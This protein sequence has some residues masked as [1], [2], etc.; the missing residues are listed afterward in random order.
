M[1]IPSPPPSVLVD[2]PEEDLSRLGDALLARVEDVLDLTVAR[3]NRSGELVDAAAQESF[4]RICTSSTRAVA[5][6]IAGES[7]AAAQ[8]A[9]RETWQVFG[10]L[11]AHRGASLHEVTRRCL[12]WRNVMAEVLQETAAQTEASPDVLAKA[13]HLLQLSLEF[14]LLRMCTCFEDAIYAPTR[15]PAPAG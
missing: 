14:S 4:E 12:L 8:D 7:L 1:R 10:E 15:P 3:T 9:G 13:L 2:R 6:W 11:A 5:G